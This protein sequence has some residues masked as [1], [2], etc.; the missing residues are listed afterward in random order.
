MRTHDVVDCRSCQGHALIIQRP[1][2]FK[3]L[4]GLKFGRWD[5]LHHSGIMIN[6]RL[7]R[8]WHCRCKCGT[9][10]LICATSLARGGTLSC[11][12]YSKEMI[13]KRLQDGTNGA[14]YRSHG[15]S[16]HRVFPV[17]R[18]MIDRCYSK[19]A[20]SYHK[21]GARGITVCDRWR[22]ED[23]FENFIADMG[24][25]GPND[26]IERRDNNG[27]YCPEN[28]VWAT[29]KEQARNR[30][31][32]VWVEWQGQRRCLAEV[33]EM[34]SVNYKML[35]KRHIKRGIPLADAVAKGK[36]CSK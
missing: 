18:G 36:L 16:N 13:E 15:L 5:V 12:C 14:V 35:W 33:A 6:G 30:R 20:T 26:T 21:Y 17:Y 25:P 7:S 9:E 8:F 1:W 28:C 31:V 10:R 29:P 2:K 4:A 23:G 32:T 11:G 3:N 34:E 19:K 24:I 22:G 27:P